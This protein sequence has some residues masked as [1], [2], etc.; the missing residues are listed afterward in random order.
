MIKNVEPV[1]LS[2]DNQQEMA[3]RQPKNILDRAGAGGRWADMQILRYVA[4]PVISLFKL[5]VYETLKI[6]QKITVWRMRSNSSA[7]FRLA[8][9]LYWGPF[10]DCLSGRTM[11]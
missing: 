3:L 6:H 8:A 9:R 7:P 10:D 5:L 11:Y 1:E 4:L 2:A